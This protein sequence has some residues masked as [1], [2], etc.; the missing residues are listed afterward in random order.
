MCKEAIRKCVDIAGGQTALVERMKPFLPEELSRSFRQGHLSNW[1]NRERKSQVP[2]AE[3]VPAMS[4]S[5]D[6]KVSE[7]QLRPDIFVAPANN[8][9]AA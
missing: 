9:D 3:Y 7:H 4:L 5:V 2:P 6:F 8:Q 1:L